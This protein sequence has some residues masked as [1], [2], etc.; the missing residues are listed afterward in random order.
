MS[1]KRELMERSI[2]VREVSEKYPSVSY[3]ELS[4]VIQTLQTAIDNEQ[5]AVELFLNKNIADALRGEGFF[6]VP[7]SGR[8]V[9]FFNQDNHAKPEPPEGRVLKETE[10]P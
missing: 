1:L 10:L 3:R 2:M 7:D 6:V 8:C 9:I 4:N 5:N